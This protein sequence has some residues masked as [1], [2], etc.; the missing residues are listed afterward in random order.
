[1]YPKL[2]SD[3][4][5]KL[6]NSQKKIY[7]KYYVLLY[8]ESSSSK[9]AFI[10]SKKV[11]NAVIRN[12]CKRYLREIIRIHQDSILQKHILIICKKNCKEAIHKQL[13]LCEF[14]KDLLNALKKV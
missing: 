2:T 11:G 5:S 6:Q 3:E 14:E 4:I 12:Q 7:S 9:F 1:V 8:S 13:N 10:A